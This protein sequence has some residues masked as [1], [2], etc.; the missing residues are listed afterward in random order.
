MAAP[1]PKAAAVGLVGSSL[2]GAVSVCAAPKPLL[3]SVDVAN[4]P[5]PPVNVV[6]D[7]NT[8][9]ADPAPNTGL[10][11]G[12]SFAGVDAAADAPRAEGEPNPKEVAVD[13]NA[14]PPA[15]GAEPNAFDG[16]V[17][18][19]ASDE[20]PA[21]ENDGVAKLKEGAEPVPKTG[22]VDGTSSGSL[23]SSL[24]YE[25]SESIDDSSSSKCKSRP[26]RMHASAASVAG[27]TGEDATGRAT[28]I[29]GR[30]MLMSASAATPSNTREKNCSPSIS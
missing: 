13:P 3:L 10:E 12:C 5:K 1:D 18:V 21:K 25:S 9:A 6:L 8:G 2:F 19:F 30:A 11:A 23:S 24:L 7:P 27:A 26:L 28:L 22:C 14:K 29:T 20:P 4:M 17:V 15:V 16:V